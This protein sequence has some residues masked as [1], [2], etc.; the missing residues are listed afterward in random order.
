MF[1]FSGSSSGEF[2]VRFVNGTGEGYSSRVKVQKGATIG[3]F[4]QERLPDIRP[5]GLV[6][7]VT[8][9]DGTKL[10]PP[11][12]DEVLQQGDRITATEKKE[13]AGA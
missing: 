11:S 3:Q 12:A 2:E 7:R 5:N 6:I 9:A 10:D 8:R 1:G 4:I 13:V